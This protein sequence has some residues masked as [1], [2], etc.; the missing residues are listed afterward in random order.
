MDDR[1]FFTYEKLKGIERI[2]KGY[3]DELATDE[4]FNAKKSH[5]TIKIYINN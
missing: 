3:I 2:A 5:V 1:G 4:V